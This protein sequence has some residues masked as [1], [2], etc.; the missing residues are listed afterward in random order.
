MC[1]INHCAHVQRLRAMHTPGIDFG[2]NDASLN[3]SPLVTDNCVVY[4]S[5]HAGIM[6]F[7]AGDNYRTLNGSVEMDQLL[8]ICDPNDPI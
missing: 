8:A 4:F 6:W 7:V 1:N 5:I 3:R 2:W